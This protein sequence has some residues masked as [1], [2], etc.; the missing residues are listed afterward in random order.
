MDIGLCLWSLSS[1]HSPV[2]KPCVPLLAHS[3]SN[4]CSW[5]M[6]R[7][8]DRQKA[9]QG[10][11]VQLKM[12]GSS[13]W[14]GG[15]ARWHGSGAITCCEPRGMKATFIHQHAPCCDSQLLKEPLWAVSQCRMGASQAAFCPNLIFLRVVF[16][17]YSH[18]RAH[19]LWAARGNR[20]GIAGYS[21]HF[22]SQGILLHPLPSARSA[23]WGDI[24]VSS[25]A[26]TSGSGV[27]SAGPWGRGGCDASRGGPAAPQGTQL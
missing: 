14:H 7:Q 12:D 8:A 19:L 18:C 25:H 5:Q 2:T 13:E 4:G 10:K 17:R 23:L 1:T 3:V 6:D 21:G 20:M 26:G 15:T 16:L 11:R 9:C 27:A 22:H 24:L